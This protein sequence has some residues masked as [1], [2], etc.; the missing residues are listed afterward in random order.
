MQ[1]RI[2]PRYR[3]DLESLVAWLARAPADLSA[4][5]CGCTRAANRTKKDRMDVRIRLGEHLECGWLLLIR[6]R[7]AWR[8]AARPC[9]FQ[10]REQCRSKASPLPRRRL[11]RMVCG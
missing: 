1:T 4:P 3:R 11:T 5:S 6:Q 9:L 8:A 2:T 10:R 7:T